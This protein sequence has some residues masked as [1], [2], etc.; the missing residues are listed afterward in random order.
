L[1]SPLPLIWAIP[2]LPLDSF[3]ICHVLEKTYNKLSS[4]AAIVII[5]SILLQWRY[6]SMYRRPPLTVCYMI[7][8][9]DFI[10]TTPMNTNGKY[11]FWYNPH[12]YARKGEEIFPGALHRLIFKLHFTFLFGIS[13][14]GKEKMLKMRIH[15]LE[16]IL[17]QQHHVDIECIYASCQNYWIKLRQN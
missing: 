2:F 1:L 5:A 4:F 3:V 12:H 15:L 9:N 16:P 14:F 6:G 8:K 10:N 7:R 11:N 17:S 13:P